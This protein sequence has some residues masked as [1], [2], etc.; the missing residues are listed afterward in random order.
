MSSEQ[1]AAAFSGRTLRVERLPHGVHHLV[2]ARPAVRNAIDGT[3]AEELAVA[4]GTLADLGPQE[5]RVL[6]VRG[7]GDFFSAGADIGYMREQAAR[8]GRENLAAAARLALAFHSLAA[9]P[10]PV[11]GV[12]KGAAMGGGLGLLACCD[13]VVAEAAALAALPEAR[14]GVL[15]AVISPYLLRKVGVSHTAAL[16]FSGRRFTADELLRMGFVQRVVAATELPAA[17]E[18]LVADVLRGGPEAQRR[19]KRLLLEL[20][21]LPSPAVEAATAGAIAEARTS[22]EAR[23]GFEAFLARQDPPWVP[24]SPSPEDPGPR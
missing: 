1:T 9:L 16:A 22:Q 8:S 7:E 21:P 6:V 24:A 3:M 10:A 19:T 5:L 13:L 20:A 17:L 4:L 12:L 14:L 23:T 2:L 11:V 18:E 15:P